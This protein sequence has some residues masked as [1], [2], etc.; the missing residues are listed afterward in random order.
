MEVSTCCSNCPFCPLLNGL[1]LLCLGSITSK[2]VNNVCRIRINK[3]TPCEAPLGAKWVRAIYFGGL[4]SSLFPSSWLCS[5]QKGLHDTSLCYIPI[6]D[7]SLS[8][9]LFVSSK[10]PLP[11]GFQLSLVNGKSQKETGGYEERDIEVR[12]SNPSFSGPCSLVGAATLHDHRSWQVAL[13]QGSR[14]H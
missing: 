4:V 5:G 1:L 12:I 14:S 7:L 6:S 10:V 9:A 2:T 13:L 3:I 11:A 8:F